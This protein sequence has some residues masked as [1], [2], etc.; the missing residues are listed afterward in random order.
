MEN[1]ENWLE[2]FGQYLRLERGS[3]PHTWEAYR[4][5]LTRFAEW[6]NV[7]ADEVTNSD[8]ENFMASLYDLGVL[9]ST[10]ARALS[11]IKSFYRFLLLEQAIVADPCERVDS[12]KIGRKLPEI[13]A[14]DEINQMLSV[15]GHDLAG[16]RGKAIIETLYACGLRVSELIGL[17]IE[18]IDEKEG[19]VKVLGKG[20][21]ERMVPIGSSALSAIA[22]YLSNYRQ[23]QVP[24][25]K[26][27]KYLFLSARGAKLTRSYVFAFIKETAALCNLSKKI[28]PHTFRHSFATH[29]IENGAG[30]RSVQAMLG[31]ESINTTQI[32]THLDM[33]HLRNTLSSFHPLS[34]NY[35]KQ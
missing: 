29:L 3:S 25:P 31:H 17:E 21:K 9:A 12:P 20:R 16:L 24:K 14:L 10:Q 11:A 4:R 33:R 5:D 28:S 34:K 35:S 19:F 1:W 30:L 32:Y 6:V 7:S 27:E 26:S 2:N 18:K 23:K 15:L 8:V 22:L 13:L